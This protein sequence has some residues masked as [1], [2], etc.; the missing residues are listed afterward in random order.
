[1]RRRGVHNAQNCLM[2]SIVADTV[3]SQGELTESEAVRHRFNPKRL[4][5]LTLKLTLTSSTSVWTFAPRPTVLEGPD[6]TLLPRHPATLRA[7]GN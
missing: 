4:L 7:Q 5:R 6:L 3:A 1:V 2:S